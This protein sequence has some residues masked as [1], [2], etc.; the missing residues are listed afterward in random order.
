[1][2]K[3]IKRLVAKLILLLYH[4]ISNIKRLENLNFSIFELN[5]IVVNNQL[6]WKII[7]IRS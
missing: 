5:Q 3:E 6:D 2:P 4:E 1:M 7:S